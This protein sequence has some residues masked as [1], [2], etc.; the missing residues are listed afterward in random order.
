LAER[1]PSK[2]NVASSSLVSRSTVYFDNGA[3]VRLVGRRGSLMRVVVLLALAGLGLIFIDIRMP[4]PDVP[5]AAY[6]GLLALVLALVLLVR[7][8]VKRAT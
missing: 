2:L 5:Y 7:R 6:A 3:S 4:A 8:L 1:Q